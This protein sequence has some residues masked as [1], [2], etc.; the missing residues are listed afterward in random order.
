MLSGLYPAGCVVGVGE[1]GA[2]GVGGP[3]VSAA[4]CVSVG[5]GV[6]VGVSDGLHLS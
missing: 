3:Y 5:G 2:A 4:G 1:G 6:A